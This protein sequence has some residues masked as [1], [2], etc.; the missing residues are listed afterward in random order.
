[1]HQT[2][3]HYFNW[4]HTNQT[5]KYSVSVGQDNL[6]REDPSNLACRSIS[7]YGMSMHGIIHSGHLWPFGQKLVSQV[8]EPPVEDFA[9]VV[10]RTPYINKDFKKRCQNGDI[11]ISDYETGFGTAIGRNVTG[12]PTTKVIGRGDNWTNELYFNVKQF[13]GNNLPYPFEQRGYWTVSGWWMNSVFFNIDGTWAKPN[14]ST[15]A[16]PPLIE[17]VVTTIGTFADITDVNVSWIL[18]DIKVK[19]RNITIRDD[20]VQEALVKAN[21]GDVDALTAVAEFPETV[22]SIIDGFKLIKKILL[23]WKKKDFQLHSKADALAR[24]KAWNAYRKHTADRMRRFPSYERWAKKRKRSHQTH[25]VLE[26]NREREYFSDKALTYEQYWASK[27]FRFRKSAQHELADAFASI[28]LNARYNIA[29]N[30]MLLED[31]GDAVLNWGDEFVRYREKFIDESGYDFSKW[32]PNDTV[33]FSGTNIVTERVLIK[34]QYDVGS[35]L[36]KLGKALMADVVVTGVELI[37]L[38]SII[39]DWFFTISSC[40]KAINWNP[41]HLQ[42]GSCY[43]MKTEV[44]GTLE[45]DLKDSQGKPVTAKAEFDF[46]GYKR[47]IINPYA[48]IGIRW[49]PDLSLLRQLD[50]LAFFWGSH[51]NS[52]KTYYSR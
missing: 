19:S 38:W 51:R 28:E 37:R 12:S 49:N 31:I 3:Y 34:R 20:M 46:D 47:I 4:F 22:Q 10:F 48:S 42:Q 23:D 15:T 1:M 18:E 7:N 2:K 8:G 35:N 25:S 32:F 50:A 21:S 39:A 44:H 33:R 9:K 24:T 30:I 36:K 29:T 6:V 52:L 16:A 43:S 26:Y 45:V 27:E 14:V 41:Q 13:Y 5:A 17:E 11:I 40:L